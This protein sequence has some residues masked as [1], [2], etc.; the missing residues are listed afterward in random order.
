MLPGTSF[1][2]PVNQSCKRLHFLGNVT[3]PTGFPV[4]ANAGE[5]AARFRIEYSG[6]KVKEV[7][8]R[9]G[10]EATR[11]NLIYAATRIQPRATEAQ[12]ALTFI[13][14]PAREH[15]QVLLFSVPAEGNIQSIVLEGA[16]KDAMLLFGVT[17]ES[18]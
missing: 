7:P 8:L 16:G 1:R 3:A 14:D 6:G 4:G 13:K 12:R 15:Y 17:A 11:A 9:Q 2:L 10:V 18:A 5:L